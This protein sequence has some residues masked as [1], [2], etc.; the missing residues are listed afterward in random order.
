M[1]NMEIPHTRAIKILDEANPNTSC[2][3]SYTT[4]QVQRSSLDEKIVELEKA[5]AKLIMEN[6]ERSRSRAVMDY[7]QVGLPRFLDPNEISQSPKEINTK[8]E[9]TM[10]ELERVHAKCTTSQVPLM[11]VTRANV[12]IQPTS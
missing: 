6:A 8:L 5:H 9:A 11:E 3:T 12:Q 7:S 2:N 4:P 1:L 10:A